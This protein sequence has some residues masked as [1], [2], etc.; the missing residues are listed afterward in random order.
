M[1]EPIF[2]I[3]LSIIRL[4]RHLL[5]KIRKHL[6]SIIMSDKK[7]LTFN[8][9]C[10][11]LLKQIPEGKV[12]TYKALANALGTKAYQAVGNAMNKNPNPYV[13]PCHR[14][15]Q[16]NG[17]LGGFAYGPKEKIALLKKEGVH[18]EDNKVVDFKIHFFDG[19]QP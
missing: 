18:I 5:D 3:R 4:K 13:V 10:Y 7:H 2:L 6:E 8:Q 12:S 9:Q 16:T 11:E 15:V 14:V 1:L 19:F 17:E